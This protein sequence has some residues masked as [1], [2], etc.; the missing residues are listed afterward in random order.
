MRNKI[1]SDH[2]GMPW[3]ENLTAGTEGV[4]AVTASGEAAGISTNCIRKED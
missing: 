3:S 4:D 2:S 1:T